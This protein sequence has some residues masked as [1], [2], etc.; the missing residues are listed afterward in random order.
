MDGLAMDAM[1]GKTYAKG[2]N[3]TLRIWTERT[4]GHIRLHV[5]DNGTGIPFELRRK[6]FDPFFTTKDVGAGLGLGLS[7]CH[8]IVAD[9]RGRVHLETEEGVFTDFILELVIQES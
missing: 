7:V 9:M 3:P 2:E 4:D 6:I 5:R 1:K 8:R